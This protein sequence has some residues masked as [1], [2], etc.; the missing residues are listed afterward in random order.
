MRPFWVLLVVTLIERA[1]VWPARSHP[2]TILKLLAARMARKVNPDKPRTDGQRLLSGTLA[3]VVLLLPIA[4]ILALLI[5]LAHYPVF[6]NG[7]ALYLALQFEPYRRHGKRIAKQ[8]RGDKRTLAK[9]SLNNLVLRDTDKLSQLGIGKATVEALCL[10]FNYQFVCVSFWFLLTG[11]VG[12]LTYRMLLEFSYEWNV[13]KQRY[14]AFGVP[15]RRLVAL[16]QWLPTR[17]LIAVMFITDG[18]IGVFK[19]LKGTNA[20]TQNRPALLGACGGALG[21]QLSGPMFYEGNKL[22][23]TRVGGPREMKFSDM[24]R[25]FTMLN[26]LQLALFCVYLLGCVTAFAI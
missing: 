18:A 4:I 25:A 7:L 24:Q 13:K 2:N 23:F 8:L 11:G 26:R 20:L 6:F 14:R 19:G 21:C 5:Q 1:W 16:L 3:I 22:R 9:D 15:V 17:L 12:A 10:R